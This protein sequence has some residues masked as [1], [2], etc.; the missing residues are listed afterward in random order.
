[1]NT[2][3]VCYDLKNPEI[4]TYELH[5]LLKEFSDYIHMQNSVWI[6]KAYEDSKFIYNYLRKAL[7]KMDNILIIKVSRDYYGASATE[8]WTKL[9][10]FF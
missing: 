10:K 4:N 7:N 2:Y 8:N 5:K 6:V 9:S 3:L 1:M